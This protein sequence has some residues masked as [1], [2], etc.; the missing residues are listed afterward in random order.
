[1]AMAMPDRATMLASTPTIFIT[2]N[3]QITASGNMPA[4]TAEAR[5]LTT[6][7]STTMIQI[8]TSWV[9]ASSSVPMVS[10]ISCV[11]S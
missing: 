2:M 10:R 1:M 8:S 7:I 5:R 11:R 3:V 6:S 4:I 9:S